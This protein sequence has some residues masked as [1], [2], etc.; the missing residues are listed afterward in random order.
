MRIGY[1]LCLTSRKFSREMTTMKNN[2][3]AKITAYFIIVLLVLSF[4]I[5]G[6]ADYLGYIGSQHPWLAKVNQTEIGREEV[7]SEYRETLRSV[8]LSGLDRDQ[9]RQINLMETILNRIID[10]LLLEEEAQNLGMELNIETLKAYIEREPQFINPENNRFD[11]LLFNQ[12]LRNSGQ[13]EQGFVQ[14]LRK[15]IYTFLI[16]RTQLQFAPPALSER[17]YNWQF[18]ERKVKIL[19]FNLPPAEDI[20]KPSDSTLQAYYEDNTDSFLAPQNRNIE[21]IQIQFNDVIAAMNINASAIEERYELEKERF[22]IAQN[23]AVKRIL[24][25]DKETAEQALADYHLQQ[26]PSFAS[27]AEK[28]DQKVEDLGIMTKGTGIPAIEDAIFARSTAGITPVVDLPIGFGLFFVDEI[29]PQKQLTLED[30]EVRATIE[31]EIKIDRAYDASYD[32]S[33]EL[34]DALASGDSFAKVASDLGL[35]SRTLRHITATGADAFTGAQI[36]NITNPIISEI[37]KTPVG[38][39]SLVLEDGNNGYFVLRVLSETPENVRPFED[40]RN[41]VFTSW[42]FDA[43]MESAVNSLLEKAQAFT[44]R[45]VSLDE[46]ETFA[47]EMAVSADSSPYFSRSGQKSNRDS[48]GTLPPLNLVDDVYSMKKGTI[49]V[50]KGSNGPILLWLENIQNP[51][52]KSIEGLENL[53]AAEWNRTTLNA[54]R[55]ALQQNL[56]QKATI[57]YNY[58][59]IEAL[60]DIL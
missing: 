5:W 23:A 11:P 36:P 42:L 26:E 31:R 9:A 46:I 3:F 45:E 50:S 38:E 35:E 54:T 24:F 10:D 40:I 52:T 57:D 14:N 29:E 41:L 58:D 43:R 39:A 27:I 7:L 44:G 20:S 21:I 34:T 32:R 17:L 25:T 22:F 12:Y 16:L 48:E 60:Y 51:S 56:R 15:D 47:K 33:I 53:A 30:D 28:F 8:G 6:I 18:E 55:E 2:L 4:G 49:L 19:G 59:A 37:F 13:S 1:N